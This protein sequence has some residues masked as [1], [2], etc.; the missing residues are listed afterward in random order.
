MS[1][2]TWQKIDFDE[3]SHLPAALSK[4]TRFLFFPRGFVQVHFSALGATV[5]KP[6]VCVALLVLAQFHVDLD[7]RRGL[8]S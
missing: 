6:V 7:E 1:E 5:R 8:P 3:N 4:P 2:F